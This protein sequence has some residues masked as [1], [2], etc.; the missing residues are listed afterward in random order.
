MWDELACIEHTDN[1]MQ[2]KFKVWL[3]LNSSISANF[4]E[5]CDIGSSEARLSKWRRDYQCFS[6]QHDFQ[7]M[8]G[9]PQLSLFSQDCGQNSSWS[10]FYPDHHQTKANQD[11]KE[12]AYPP[13]RCFHRIRICYQEYKHLEHLP[14]SQLLVRFEQNTAYF[15]SQYSVWIDLIFVILKSFQNCLSKDP[16]QRVD[17][18]EESPR[19]GPWGRGK[20]GIDMWN[21][22]ASPSTV[23]GTH[24]HSVTY[25]AGGRNKETVS[26]AQLAPS[27]G[28]RGGQKYP[29]KG[30]IPRDIYSLRRRLG[31]QTSSTQGQIITFLM[32]PPIHQA[33][34]PLTFRKNKST[35]VRKFSWSHSS[36]DDRWLRKCLGCLLAAPGKYL[37]PQEILEAAKFQNIIKVMMMMIS[38]LQPEALLT[39]ELILTHRR[40]LSIQTNPYQALS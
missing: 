31:F 17:E 34:W 30:Y 18:K 6:T 40:V 25:S 14:T 9:A 26:R 27:A 39:S 37:T 20:S 36:A 4:G 5:N 22:A 13:S 2:Q 33:A 21:Y 29:L 28:G 3:E 1:Q 15:E 11:W 32:G 35:S 38:P 23:L 19:A 24:T 10:S 8:S 16:D 12:E 7:P